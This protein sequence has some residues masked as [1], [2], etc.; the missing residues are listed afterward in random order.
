V[1]RL[2]ANIDFDRAPLGSTW[3]DSVSDATADSDGFE[4]LMELRQASSGLWES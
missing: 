3:S 4:G 1:V 2:P